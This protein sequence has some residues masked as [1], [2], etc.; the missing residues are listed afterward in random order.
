MDREV[1]VDRLEVIFREAAQSGLIVD[2]FGLVPAYR[3]LGHD[4]FILGVSAPSLADEDCFGKTEA[5]IDCLYATLGEP[6]RRMINRVRVFDNK[7]DLKA[8]AIN[9]FEEGS[10]CECDFFPELHQVN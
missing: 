6:E 1:L 3:G 9:D 10:T 4:S 8:H 2:Y 5:I 7:K